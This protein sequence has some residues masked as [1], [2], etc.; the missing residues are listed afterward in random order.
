MLDRMPASDEVDISEL[1][2]LF[3]RYIHRLGRGEQAI[4]LKT[5]FC[6]VVELAASRTSLNQRFGNNL[7]DNILEWSDAKVSYNAAKL[8]SA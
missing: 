4:R 3:G 7:L 1:V 6:N 8:T 5:K 2:M